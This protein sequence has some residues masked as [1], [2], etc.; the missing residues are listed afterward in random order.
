MQASIDEWK[1]GSFKA[2]ELDANKQQVM[3][4]RHLLSLYEYERTAE[5]RL[6]RF[7]K[8]WFEAGL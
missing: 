3:Y 8:K 7:R 2:E 4:E 1:L 5:S 6:T